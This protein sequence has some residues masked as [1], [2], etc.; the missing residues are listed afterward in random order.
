MLCINGYKIHHKKGPDYV[1]LMTCLTTVSNTSTPKLLRDKL[2]VRKPTIG[3][4]IFRSQYH[5]FAFVILHVEG[6]NHILQVQP[7][8]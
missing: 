6:L 4:I 8:S 2:K 1:L 7:Q 3:D 5:H